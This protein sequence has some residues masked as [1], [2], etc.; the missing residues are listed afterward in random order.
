M[1]TS[2]LMV[3]CALALVMTTTGALAQERGGSLTFAR[4]DG[5]R[6]IDPIYADRNPD[7]WM[8][9][10]LFDTL[11]VTSD[12]GQS[13]EPGLAESYDVS[14]D[15]LTL[16]LTLREGVSFSDGSPMSGDDVVFSLERA[17]NPDLSPWSGLL[18]SVQSVAADGNVI[19]ITLSQPD[20]TIVSILAT[21]NTAIVSKSAFDMAEGD[22]DQA[23]SEAL[24]HQTGAGVGSGPFYLSGFSQGGSMEFTAN[25]HYWREGADG[26]PLPYLDT[27]AFEVIP[28]D[29]TRI[30]KLQSGEVDAAEFIPFS[31]V[32]ELEADTGINMELFPSTRIIYSPI[33]TRETR[34]DGSDNPLADSRVRQA[35]NYATD[36]QALIQLVLQGN[37]APMSSPLMASTTLLASDMS[38]LF[39]YDPEMA[40]QLLAEAG[41]EN[42]TEIT[43]TILAG[44][45][46][47]STTFAALQQM[48][49]QVGI[50]L[51][52]EQVDAPT[53]GE[54][55]RSG[56]FDIHTYGWVNDVNDPSQVVG[57]LGYYPTANAVG[58][59]WDNAE[60]NTL[61]EQANQE[62][63][64]DKRREMYAEMQQIYADAAPLL[65]MW[66][67]PFAVALSSEVN[68]FV[69]TP[70]G[71]N[72]FDE[73]WLER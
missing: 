18:S 47:D 17:R 49:A 54:M 14:D 29:A 56:N 9:T 40:R 21:F 11:L 4:Y 55:N 63:D 13:I 53:R 7:I 41:F 37:G 10:S 30:L 27:V 12:D 60:F 39:G 46:D 59:G 35:L 73:T 24:F 65:L 31:R 71:N 26:Q 6:L 42:S 51:V 15:G 38:P 32:A 62:M 44:S 23:K 20:P 69:Q 19:T 52:V 36:K 64:Q 34:A 43:F 66:E 22:T 61:F 8:V 33:N 57:W 67:T 2:E 68:G 5:S 1:R 16:S 50:N 3:S 25:P 45:A 72:D 58:T 70:L 48:W 28:D